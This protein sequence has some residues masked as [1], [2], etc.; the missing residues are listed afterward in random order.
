MLSVCYIILFFINLSGILLCPKINGKINGLKSFVAAVMALLCYQ[1]ASSRFFSLIQIKIGLPTATVSLLL[2]AVV[3]WTR[4]FG[5]RKIQRLFFRLSDFAGLLI[6]VFFTGLLSLHLFSFDLNLQYPATDAAGYYADAFAL[7]CTGNGERLSFASFTAAIFMELLKPVFSGAFYV[8]SFLIADIFLHLMEACMIYTLFLTISDKKIVRLFAP[9]FSLGYYFGFPAYSYLSGSFVPWSS[10]VLLWM[11]LLYALLIFEKRKGGQLSAGILLLT[12]IF[13]GGLSDPLFVWIYVIGCVSALFALLLKKRTSFASKRRFALAVTAFFLCAVSAALFCTAVWEPL[14]AQAASDTTGGAGIYSAV[15]ADLIFFLPALFY[16]AYFTFFRRK[17]RI[18]ESVSVLCT[19]SIALV[20]FT[21]VFLYRGWYNGDFTGFF[22]YRIYYVLWLSGWLLSAAALAIACE[23]KELAQY[24]SYFGMIAGLSAI[25]LFDY[26]G[27]MME[28]G[29]Y[30]DGPY[31]TKNFFSLYRYN[32]ELMHTDYKSFRISDDL[33]AV[34][35]SAAKQYQQEPTPLVTDDDTMR[36]WYDAL[37][38][39]QSDSYSLTQTDFIELLRSFDENGIRHIM[40]SR[41]N[42]IYLFYQSYFE[43]CPAIESER[44]GLYSIPGDTWFDVF[45]LQAD[46]ISAKVELFSYVKEQLP[47]EI[48]PLM[49]HQAAFMDFLLF[50]TVTGFDSAEF[51]AWKFSAADNLVNLNA[52]G[53]RY[54]VMLNGEEFYE[55]GR[56][57]YDKQQIIYENEAGKII[58]CKGDSFSTTYR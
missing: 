27:I 31:T 37:T 12:V 22:Y 33:L 19:S 29:Y 32:M 5:K 44:V 35:D 34:Y 24:M 56:D 54:I 6:P 26:D 43:R 45:D 49:A 18:S 40:L 53:V 55:N 30:F 57:Y 4:I 58:R 52:H 7:F 21:A 17:S 2:P 41:D 23:K 39:S 42:E 48:V 9:L 13:A 16:A 47:G 46:E 25:V 8:K 20:I 10:A 3:L 14:L 1:T 38:G 15:Y 51:Y 28:K 36:L 11:M 50:E